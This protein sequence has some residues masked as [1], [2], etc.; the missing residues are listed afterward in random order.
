[1]IKINAV[2]ELF[3]CRQKNVNIY[4]SGGLQIILVNH[5]IC[6]LQALSKADESLIQFLAIFVL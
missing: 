5:K 3:Q 6:F 2:V 1:M 4:Y